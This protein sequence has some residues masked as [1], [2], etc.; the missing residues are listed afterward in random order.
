M[1]NK[2]PTLIFMQIITRILV[3]RKIDLDWIEGSVVGTKRP[4]HL[5]LPARLSMSN[6]QGMPTTGQCL[7][8]HQTV[9]AY[10][11]HLRFELGNSHGIQDWQSLNSKRKYPR[12]NS[13]GIFFCAC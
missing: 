7:L 11:K 1:P 13:G 4:V 2:N 10:L 9:F 8:P 3:L 6:K 5:N 12:S